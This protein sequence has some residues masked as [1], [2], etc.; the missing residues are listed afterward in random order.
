VF[1]KHRPCGA[2]QADKQVG[3]P[4][5][6]MNIMTTKRPLEIFHMD[7]FGSIV[8]ISIKS[9]KYDLVIIDDYSCFTWVFFLHDKGETQEV[10]K[11]FLKRA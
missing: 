1:E 4:H 6:A 8:Y 5:H 3:A 10:L 2:C 9:N 11:K 7:L